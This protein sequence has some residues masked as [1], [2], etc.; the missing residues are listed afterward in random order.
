MKLLI[1][2]TTIFIFI[3]LCLLLVFYI[4]VNFPDSFIAET[5]VKIFGKIKTT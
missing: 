4:G 5:L 3:V 1:Y 2:I